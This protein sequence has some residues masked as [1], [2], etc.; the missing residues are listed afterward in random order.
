VPEG[1]DKD[2]QRIDENGWGNRLVAGWQASSIPLSLQEGRKIS[3]SS[4]PDDGRR[5]FL[6]DEQKSPYKRIFWKHGLVARQARRI[7]LS[8]G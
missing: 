7:N 8:R 6:F 1:P 4:I 3:W 2:L 5:Q